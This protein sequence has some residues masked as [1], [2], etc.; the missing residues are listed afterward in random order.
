MKKWI[1]VLLI[2]LSVL[3]VFVV[4]LCLFAGN[5]AYDFALSR[6]ADRTQLFQAE[7]NQFSDESN[8]ANEE[9]DTS[10]EDWLAET[11]YKEQIITSEFDGI[12]LHA[13]RIYQE[14]P[15]NRWA[16]LC[17]GYTGKAQQMLTSA[18]HFYETGYNIMLPDARGHGESGGNYIGMGWHDRL[19]LVQWAEEITK[20]NANAQIVLYGVSMGGATVMMASGE[21]LPVNVKA[22][23]EDCGYTS[24]YD[25]F[26][27]QLKELFGIP[28]FPLMNAASL[29]TKVRAG[30]FLEEASAVNQLAKTKTPIMFIH[31]TADTF[32]PSEMVYEVYEAAASDKKLLIVEDALHGQAAKTLG[33]EYWREVEFFLLEYLD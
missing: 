23:V 15:S 26:S 25:E 32:V 16:I 13:Y 10:H 27:Y 18:Q 3:V 9:P 33:E 24:V 7:H 11:G 17:H 29:I 1:K 20:E 4:G 6:D 5:L 21:E 19:D 31:G 28:E 8:T 30:F 22:I 14:Q 2:V 12:S